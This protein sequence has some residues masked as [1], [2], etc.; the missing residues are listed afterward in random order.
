[1]SA[2]TV[3]LLSVTAM[4]TV[5]GLTMVLTGTKKKV[6]SWKTVRKRCAA[7]GRSDRRNC[8]CRRDH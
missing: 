5:A 7:C 1:M 6:L 8:T 2:A 3:H 4:T